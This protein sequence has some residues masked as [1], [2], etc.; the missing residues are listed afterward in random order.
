M[1]SVRRLVKMAPVWN[2]HPELNVSPNS[3]VDFDYIAIELFTILFE[4]YINLAMQF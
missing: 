3:E 1:K 2:V 4:N